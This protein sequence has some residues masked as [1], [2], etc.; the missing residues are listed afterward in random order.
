[1]TA[2]L[3]TVVLAAEPALQRA[4]E[5]RCT[6]SGARVEVLDWRAPRCKGELAP[7]PVEA[8][9]RVPVRVRGARCDEWGWATVRLTVE[10]P[11]LTRTVRAGEP[12]DGAW[13]SRPV[14]VLRG[15][16]LLGAALPP[17]ITAARPLRAGEPLLASAVRLGPPP[18]S[19]ILVRVE[20]G[21]IAVEQPGSVVPCPGLA[22]CAVLP[23]GRRVTGRLESQVLLVSPEGGRL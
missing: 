3:L 12:L 19:P 18:G 5:A 21:G 20:L 17:G 15:R 4:L 10:A 1:M 9:G 23:G 11:V 2:L 6:V 7:G 13:A 16:Q 22:A 8:S 14:E